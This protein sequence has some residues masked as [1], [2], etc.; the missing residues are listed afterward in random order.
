M[1]NE[2]DGPIRNLLYVPRRLSNL[3]MAQ[4]TDDTHY[5][6]RLKWWERLLTPWRTWK[7]VPVPK[8]TE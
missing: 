5:W 7:R 4:M 1:S 3:E 6:V 2:P 8:E